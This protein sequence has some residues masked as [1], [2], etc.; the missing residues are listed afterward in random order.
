MVIKNLSPLNLKSAAL[1]IS[2]HINKYLALKS[3][4]G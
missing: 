3:L 2:C 4:V 1:I